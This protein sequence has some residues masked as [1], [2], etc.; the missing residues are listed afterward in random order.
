[1][2][3]D[4]VSGEDEN[5]TAIAMNSRRPD[6]SSRR[7]RYG[8]RPATVG[9]K[10]YDPDGAANRCQA[11]FSVCWMD[12]EEEIT[13][14]RPHARARARCGGFVDP[15]TSPFGAAPCNAQPAEYAKDIE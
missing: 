12:D 3:D 4:E 2:K 1:M 13:W 5:H 9:G 8:A 14:R 7:A 10:S 15:T 11:L 6:S